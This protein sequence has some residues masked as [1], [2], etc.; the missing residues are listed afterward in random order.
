MMDRY[1]VGLLMLVLLVAVAGCTSPQ[2]QSGYSG[3]YAPPPAAPA[4]VSQQPAPAP[5]SAV[6]PPTPEEMA[7][8]MYTGRGQMFADTSNGMDI[9]NLTDAEL[10]Q[11]GREYE[12]TVAAQMGISRERVDA[13]YAAMRN[14]EW[15]KQKVLSISR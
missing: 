7:H 14:E 11:L 5:Q 4:P 8:I 13:G 12:Y 3:Q 2:T 15:Y 9:S 6:S 10:G 1:I